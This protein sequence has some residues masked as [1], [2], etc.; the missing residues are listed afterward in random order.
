MFAKLLLVRCLSA[1]LSLQ[2]SVFDLFPSYV[3]SAFLLLLVNVCSVFSACLGL[4]AFVW[5]DTV[6]NVVSYF[7]LECSVSFSR[8]VSDSFHCRFISSGSQLIYIWKSKFMF[9]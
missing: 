9:S 8:I 5:K 7:V 1:G 2:A 6:C 3:L 4:L